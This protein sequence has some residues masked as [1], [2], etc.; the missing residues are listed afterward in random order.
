MARWF[1]W[2]Y[3]CCVGVT[4]GTTTDD[5]MATLLDLQAQM[6]EMKDTLHSQ[7]MACQGVASTPG[8]AY[9]V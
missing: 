4:Y 9:T 6:K 1:I 3:L 7:T 8:L 2:M 5:L